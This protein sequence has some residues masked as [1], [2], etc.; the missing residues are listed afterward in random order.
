MDKVEKDTF[1]TDTLIKQTSRVA[2]SRLTFRP[3]DIKKQ[4]DEVIEIEEENF[5]K[6]NVTNM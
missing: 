3:S 1:L 5:N 6:K 4:V 2:S